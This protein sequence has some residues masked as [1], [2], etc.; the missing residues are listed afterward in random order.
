[1]DR[2]ASPGLHR[3]QLRKRLVVMVLSY[4]Y[5]YDEVYCYMFGDRN[6]M[7]TTVM[8]PHI[9]DHHAHGTLFV[10]LVRG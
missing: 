5:V 3:Y 7:L 8:A 2:V 9:E 6:V 10:S 4:S 1:M